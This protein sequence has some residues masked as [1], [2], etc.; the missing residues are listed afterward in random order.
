MNTAVGNANDKLDALT[1]TVNDQGALDLRLKIEEDLSQPGAHPIALFEVPASA[2]GYL[3]LTR[4][5]VA[6]TIAKMQA[7]GQGTG[8]AQSFLNA[9]DAAVAAHDYKTAYTDYGKA[10]RAAAA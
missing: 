8:N 1:I 4:D 10:Y 9:G 5:I 2:G 6:D 7:T 3:G